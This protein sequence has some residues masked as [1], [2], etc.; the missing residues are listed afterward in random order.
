MQNVS[1]F[2]SLC[3]LLHKNAKHNVPY[4]HRPWCMLLTTL[5][6]IKHV[7]IYTNVHTHVCV[8]TNTR[9][10]HSASKPEVAPPNQ[11]TNT[12]AHRT[13]QPKG[14]I[15]ISYTQKE[16]E[17]RVPGS[18]PTPLKEGLL[19]SMLAL[20]AAAPPLAYAICKPG[21]HGTDPT[22]SNRAHDKGPKEIP[23]NL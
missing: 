7:C 23:W 17:L 18:Q 12:L 11:N 13:P 19:G 6:M 10:Y 14:Q 21:N 8:C 20:L 9:A 4:P 15:Q 16:P 5:V 3:P 22:T 2:E 1:P